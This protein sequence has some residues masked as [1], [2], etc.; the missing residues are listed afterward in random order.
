M[1]QVIAH[2]LQRI[3]ELERLARH[4]SLSGCLNHYAL[5]ETLLNQPRQIA[6]IA[7]DIK[8][9]QRVNLEKSYEDGN[10]LIIRVASLLK[11]IV[12]DKD[13]VYRVGGDEFLVL[14]EDCNLSDALKIKQRIDLSEVDLYIGV[15]SGYDLEQVIIEANKNRDDIKRLTSKRY[16]QIKSN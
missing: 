8:G 9:L 1:I 3:R 10:A 16:A 2:L 7:V 4:D 15:A 5:Q 6:V 12:R 11:K 13:N 14:L